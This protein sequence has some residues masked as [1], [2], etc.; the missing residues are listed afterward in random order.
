[1]G[2]AATKS[3]SVE[4]EVKGEEAPE[5]KPCKPCCAC[6]ETKRLR[7]ACIVENGEENCVALIE[8]HRE[9]MRKLGFNI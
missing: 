9:C 5:K 7:D 4:Q 8:A 6:P 2:N 3:A 1:M